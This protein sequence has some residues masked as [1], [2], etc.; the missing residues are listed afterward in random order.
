MLLG[1]DLRKVPEELLLPRTAQRLS[2]LLLLLG[3]L[4]EDGNRVSRIVVSSGI[5]FVAAAA[6]L[7]L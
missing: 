7:L 6:A 3:L 5:V 1:I 2:L 4:G